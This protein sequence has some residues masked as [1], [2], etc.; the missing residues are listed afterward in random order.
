MNTGSMALGLLI[1]FVSRVFW[2]ILNKM[3]TYCYRFK[4]ARKI[5]IYASDNISIRITLLTILVEGYIDLVLSAFL[6]FVAIYRCESWEEFS[7]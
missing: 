2:I 3:C 7:G 1:L 6:G 5:G 4:Y